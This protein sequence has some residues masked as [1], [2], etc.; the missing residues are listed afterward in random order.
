MSGRDPCPR[1]RPDPS[2]GAQPLP[3]HRDGQPSWEAVWC[4]GIP[5][6]PSAGHLGQPAQTPVKTPPSPALP[7]GSKPLW[8]VGLPP[9]SLSLTLP[10][11]KEFPDLEGH[12]VPPRALRTRDTHTHP[13][14]GVQ[15]APQA[16]TH[17]RGPWARRKYPKNSC[18]KIIDT[19]GRGKLQTQ[20]D[21]RQREWAVAGNRPGPQPPKVSADSAGWEAD[22]GS[23]AE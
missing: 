22:G 12:T 6:G 14:A 9:V 20:R 7:Q 8:Q 13:G 18:Q 15:E 21:G 23:N 4:P 16:S 2:H 10:D 3:W 1:A 5:V 19:A 17:P 11:G